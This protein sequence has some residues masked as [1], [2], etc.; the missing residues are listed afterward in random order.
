MAFLCAASSLDDIVLLNRT[1]NK[2]LGEALDISNAIPKDSDI[3]VKGTDDYSEISDSDI[4]VVAASTG[5]YLTDRNEMIDSQVKM[6][7]DIAQK[8]KKNCKSPLILIIS[9][10]V[11]VLT[12]FFLKESQ[13]RRNNV[14]GIASSLDSS[15]FR[16]LLSKK[17]GVKQSQI[18]DAYVIGEHGDSMIPIFSNTKIDGKIVLDLINSKQK[19]E[20]TREIRDY[21]K[22]LRNFK[23]RSQYGIAKNVFDVLES[24]KH[25]RTI[26]SPTSVLLEGEYGQ[27]DVCMGVLTKIDSEGILEII[28][29]KLNDSEQKLFDFSAQTIRNNIQSI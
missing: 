1:K 26:I 23:S 6:I 9:N 8:I 14:I 7:K 11:D 20:I 28:D 24:I 15:R 21:W 3:T 25:N 5:T 22:S 12:H 10:P 17:V 27:K 18:S 4:V 29:M 19:D 2:A 16:Y 13:F